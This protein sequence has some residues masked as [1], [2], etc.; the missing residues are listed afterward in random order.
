MVIAFFGKVI[1]ISLGLGIHILHQEHIEPAREHA[2]SIDGEI[3]TLASG[4]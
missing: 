2:T 3:Q 1:C 4:Y